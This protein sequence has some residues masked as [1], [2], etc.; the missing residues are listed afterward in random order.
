MA[1][2]ISKFNKI[3]HNKTVWLVFAIFISIAFVGVYTGSQTGN[4]RADKAI[5]QVAGKLWEEDVTRQEFAAVYRDVYVLTDLSYLMQTGRGIPEN[6]ELTNQLRQQAWIRLA[7]IKKAEMMGLN[8]TDQQ[9]VE[10]IQTFPLFSNPETG[11]FNKNMYDQV[12]GTILPQR[13]RMGGTDF[14]NLIRRNVL[15]QKATAAAAQGALVTDDEIRQA[16]HLYTDMLTVDYTTLPRSIVGTVEVT[17]EDAKAYYEQNLSEFLLPKKRVVKYVEFNVSDYTNAVEITDEDVAQIYESNKQYYMIPETATN[18][19]PEY[20]PLEEVKGEIFEIVAADMS[21]RAAANAA[22]ALVAQLSAEG[23][24]FEDEAEKA[25]LTIVTD[26]P[27]FGAADQ[28]RGVDP[29]AP[30]ARAAFN[31]DLTPTQYYSDP[32]VGRD[33]VYVIALVKEI[34]E[35]QRTFDVVQAEAT[36]SARIAAAELAYVEKAEEIHAE[37]AAALKEGV[38]FADAASKYNLEIQQTA[39]FNISNPLEGEF[40]REI[41]GSTIQFDQGTLVDLISTPDEF[42][43]AYVAEKELAD[44]VVTLPGMRDDLA[45]GIRQEKAQRLAQ[46]WQESLLEEAGFEDLSVQPEET[47]DEA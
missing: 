34:D 5:S 13:Y 35:Y 4:S 46:A 22:D 31:L 18:D 47:S 33:T 11:G 3:I 25:G 7:T 20:R 43:M 24:T 32:V 15:V 26:T 16:F 30:F 38:S 37:I 41:M 44:E 29:T 17:E 21:Q 10:A 42:L 45:A 40:S 14:E 6:S 36:E 12:V 28:V 2:M 8:V 1:M 23:A 27:A 9:T 39:P 19:V